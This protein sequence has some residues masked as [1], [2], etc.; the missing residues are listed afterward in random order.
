[1]NAV[2][3]AAALATSQLHYDEAATKST[4]PRDSDSPTCRHTSVA[5]DGS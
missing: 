3:L 4:I 5:A 2:I 1:M